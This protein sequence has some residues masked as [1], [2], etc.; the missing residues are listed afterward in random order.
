MSKTIYKIH[1][2]ET[3]RIVSVY[4]QFGG[5]QTKFDSVRG[6]RSSNCHDIYE[7]ESK[8]KVCA[9]KVEEV[10]IDGDVQESNVPCRKCHGLK[11]TKC[12]FRDASGDETIITS[13]CD[14]CNGSGL[15]PEYKQQK[16]EV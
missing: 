9:Y 3:D 4:H 8:Y 11:V 5:P 12:G 10:L 14:T 16:G 15:K 13:K 2:R 1:D 7:D 6:A